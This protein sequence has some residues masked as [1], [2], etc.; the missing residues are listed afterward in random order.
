MST[1]IAADQPPSEP[2][3]YWTRYITRITLGPNGLR[4]TWYAFEQVEWNGKKWAAP[5]LDWYKAEQA[6]VLQSTSP[7]K[8]AIEHG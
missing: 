8:Q 1:W 3:F 2:G 7:H 6:G 4:K 5:V